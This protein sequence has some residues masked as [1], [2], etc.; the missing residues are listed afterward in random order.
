MH[1]ARVSLWLGY[2]LLIFLVL[3]STLPPP[4]PSL[5][6]GGRHLLMVRI[7]RFSLLL[8]LSQSSVMGCEYV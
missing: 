6:G 5:T 7:G 2:P 4:H 8:C 1:Y 3:S